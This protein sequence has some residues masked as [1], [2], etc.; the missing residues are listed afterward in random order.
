MAESNIVVLIADD[1][2][3]PGA[4][5]TAASILACGLRADASIAI[6]HPPGAIAPELQDWFAKTCP[7]VTLLPVDAKTYLP[8]PLASWN[9]ILAPLFLRFAL[10]EIFPSAK[11]IFYVDS[12]ILA[13]G[14]IDSMYDLSLRQKPFAAANNDLISEIVGAKP[15]WLAYRE[16]IGA[17]LGTSYL[18]CGVLLQ[19]TAAWLAGGIKNT[20]TQ[21]YLD[22]RE[23]CPYFDQSALNMY[24][25]GDF[26]KLSPAWN[27]QHA[28]QA[29][30]AEDIIQPRLI[31][32]AGTAKPW[33]NDGFIF[34]RAYRDRYR[35]LLRASPFAGFFEPYWKITR[36]QLKEGWRTLNRA[37]RGREIQAGI[38]RSEIAS[39]RDKFRG[40]LK[41]YDFIDAP[42]AGGG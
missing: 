4:Y 7:R 3:L 36:R 21:L 14:P 35:E 34:P 27:F 41:S 32:F 40:F 18:N 42:A 16:A 30:G 2:Y 24:V 12:D 31:H 23:L 17:P 10:P 22:N 5:A 28:Y 11:R 20:L 13:V 38:S 33:R 6:V 9:T 25:K 8:Q 1:A 19:D 26:A 39:L 37:A 15:R 29:I